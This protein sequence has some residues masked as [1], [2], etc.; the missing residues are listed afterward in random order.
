MTADAPAVRYFDAI[1]AALAGLDIF[2]RDDRS[3][4]YKH[5]LIAQVVAEYIGRLENSFGAWRNRLGFAES[6]RISRAES[7]FPVFQNVL[8]L[9]NDRKSA[10]KRLAAIPEPDA[11]RAEMADFILRH[12]EFPG[13]LQRS[14]AE[15]L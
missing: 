2:L 10:E 7:G 1:A 5:G 11:L 13:A 15:R 6:F 8:E 4:L 3:P 12:K 14:M 9:E